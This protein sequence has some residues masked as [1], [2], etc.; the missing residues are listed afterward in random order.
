M[1]RP[2]RSADAGDASLEDLIARTALGER[3]A[4]A[5]LYQATAAKLFGVLLR[6]LKHEELAEDALQDVYVKVWHHARDWHSGKGAPLTWLT[7]IARYRAIDLLRRARS[8]VPLAGDGPAPDELPATLGDPFVAS[9]RQ[10]DGARLDDCLDTLPAER[11]AC[12]VLAYCEGYTHE[13][14]SR[15]LDAPVGTV[16]S[17]I[18]RGLAALKDCLEAAGG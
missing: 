7:S 15:R 18:R 14:L 16:K 8:G 9:S 11:R 4:F 13:E 2:P 5:R 12:L 1:A 3:A 6:I 17:W 10:A